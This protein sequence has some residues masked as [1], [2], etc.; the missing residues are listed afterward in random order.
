MDIQHTNIIQRENNLYI[1][2]M[3]ISDSPEPEED[4][5]QVYFAAYVQIK[6]KERSPF[7]AELQR[8]ALDDMRKIL[9]QKRQEIPQPEGSR[10]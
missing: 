10:Q 4:Q 1:V 5:E 2:E 8:A 3:L 9:D 6:E 7:F